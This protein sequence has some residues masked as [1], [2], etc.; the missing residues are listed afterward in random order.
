MR[1]VEG[2]PPHGWVVPLDIRAD[3]VSLVV[4]GPP[5]RTPDALSDGRLR[6]AISHEGERALARLSASP[7]LDDFCRL[8]REFALRT[9]LMTPA[10][11]SFVIGCGA[12]RA[13]MCMLGH[14]AFA[15]APVEGTIQTGIGGAAGIVDT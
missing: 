2:G 1:V 13:G 12:D 11:E 9:G 14:S 7:S 10:I 3:I 6:T 8:G 4:L 5:L 15:F